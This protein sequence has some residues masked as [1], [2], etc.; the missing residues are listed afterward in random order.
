MTTHAYDD[1][2]V[3]PNLKQSLLWGNDLEPASTKPEAYFSANEVD[4]D[5]YDAIVLCMSAGKDS[6]ACLYLLRPLVRQTQRVL[7]G[8]P[9]R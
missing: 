2:V 1:A 8:R 5:S 7:A 9:V 6:L 4:L 3:I